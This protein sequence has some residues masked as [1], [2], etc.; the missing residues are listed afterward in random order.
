MGVYYEVEKNAS[1]TC[2]HDATTNKVAWHEYKSNYNMQIVCHID[3]EKDAD[4]NNLVERG[5]F[6]PRSGNATKRLKVL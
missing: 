6:K 4:R 2:P 1:D 5:V 3:E